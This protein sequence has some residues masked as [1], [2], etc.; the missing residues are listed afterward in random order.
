MLIDQDN[1]GSRKE[2]DEFH[3]FRQKKF[4]QLYY[5][6][7][8]KRSFDSGEQMNQ[9]KLCSGDLVMLKPEQEVSNYRYYCPVCEKN[10]TVSEKATQCINCG[11]KF[12]HQYAW[13]TSERTDKAR[14]RLFSI[15]L[16]FRKIINYIGKS[17]I[18][19]PQVNESSQPKEQENKINDTIEE[20]IIEQSNFSRPVIRLNF[21]SSG[22]ELPTV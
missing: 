16:F 15:K 19:K 9:C 20:I 14:M 8:C 2:L 7:K 3:L 22:E 21:F 6:P 18:K 11:N 4:K 17:R 1:Q 5:C 12:I 10:F 13:E